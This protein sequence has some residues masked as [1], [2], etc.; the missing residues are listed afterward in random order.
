MLNFFFLFFV[1]AVSAQK[2][3]EDINTENN[4]GAV[5]NSGAVSFFVV[6]KVPIYPGC[7]N[8]TNK[9]A[10]DCFSK[11]IQELV[12]NNFN[13]NL[14]AELDLPKGRNKSL[15]YF[16]IHR[17]G[18]IKDIEVTANHPRMKDEMQRI[19]FL[20]PKLKPGSQRSKPVSVRFAFPFT[21]K[22]E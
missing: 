1:F 7:E 13:F 17:S 19:L 18:K 3:S 16:T 2:K 20:M 22:V 14:P 12:A 4:D 9:D 21:I 15:I 8:L 11:K 5:N 10:R 6:E